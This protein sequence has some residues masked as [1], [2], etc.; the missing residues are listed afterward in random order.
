M[1][2]LFPSLIGS[3]G[4]M[5]FPL[6]WIAFRKYWLWTSQ[7]LR[8]FP[9][10]S[11]DRHTPPYVESLVT[12][13]FYRTNS[14]IWTP[15]M[16]RFA[17]ETGTK[18]LYGNLPEN[19]AL[20]TNHREAGENYAETLGAS[21]SLLI[22]D[23]CMENSKKQICESL[24]SFPSL[25][26]LM[27]NQ[28]D[29]GS[30]KTGNI[31]LSPQLILTADMRKHL[32]PLQLL[33]KEVERCSMPMMFANEWMTIRFWSYAID[34][35]VEHLPAT[36]RLHTWHCVPLENLLPAYVSIATDAPFVVWIVSDFNF[37]ANER[38]LPDMIV[39]LGECVGS[40]SSLGL[41]LD[42]EQSYDQV[43]T[44]CQED[45]THGDVGL[46]LYEKRMQSSVSVMVT[47]KLPDG[48]SHSFVIAVKRQS[49]HL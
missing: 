10:E 35:L 8:S 20:V 15:W 47:R 21:A 1:S 27:L 31:G 23:P 26:K 38:N 2:D 44:L 33:A 40:P 3:W 43:L 19:L 22:D 39:W 9:A 18:C 36:V 17:Y 49:E 5:F 14:N 45:L 48:F 29:F 11:V 16:V 30:R 7:R 25:Q 6:P 37:I 42:Q 28:Y 32:R 12:N 13:H 46:V 41:A 4:P 34:L 24:V